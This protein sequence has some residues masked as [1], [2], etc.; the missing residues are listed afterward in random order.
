MSTW[1]LF[2]GRSYEPTRDG[3]R[4]NTQLAAVRHILADGRWHTMTEIGRELS[5]IGIF[6]TETSISA[7]IR[8]LRKTKF[9]AHDVQSRYVDKGLWAYRMEVIS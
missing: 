3:D 6:A 4:L 9:G 2:D 5:A 7:R 1:P 8:D